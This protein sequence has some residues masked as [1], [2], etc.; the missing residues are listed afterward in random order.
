MKKLIYLLLILILS[1]TVNAQW[2]QVWNGMGQTRNVISLFYNNSMLLAGCGNYDWGI[3]ASTN[4]G[5]TWN[6]TSLTNKQV[7]D[8]I[9]IGTTTYACVENGIYVSNNGN[10]WSNS[11]LSNQYWIYSFSIRNNYMFAGTENNG[12]YYSTNNGTNWT[13][14]FLNNKTVLSI[15]VNNNYVIAGTSYSGIYYS[16]DN[17]YI[18][19]QSD[20]TDKAV[21]KI[22]YDG[23]MFYSATSNGIYTSTNNGINWIQSGLSGKN[24]KTVIFN[25]NYIYAG[26][27]VYGV[28]TS[29]KHS[30]I[31]VQIN[32]GFPS[33]DFHSSSLVFTSNYLLTGT[34]GKTIWRRPTS[35]VGIDK[36]SNFV[37]QF[38]MIYQNY[39]NPFNPLTKIIFDIRKSDDVKI[40]IFDALGR[41]ISTLVNQKL[42]P[43][44]YETTFDGGNL[45]TGI[46]F[47]KLITDT[48]SKTIKLNLVK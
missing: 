20:L 28:Y 29:I 48:Y 46:Y 13:Q 35:Q 42:L 16:T 31:W 10:D 38:S 18:W 15:A 19:N 8:F 27:E 25:G 30:N 26:A 34:Y 47:C 12:L 39:P 24:I 32:N 6:T 22:K 21:Y 2:V 4:E 37:P 44:S 14:S 43:G 3:Y 23:S 11:Y 36:K 1:S 41:T 7:Y 40:I 45:P 5:L 33:G 9:S 17:G